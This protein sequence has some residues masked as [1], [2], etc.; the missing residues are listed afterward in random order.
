L[1][2]SE[3]EKMHVHMNRTALENLSEL[4]VEVDPNLPYI[5]IGG[6]DIKSWLMFQLEYVPSQFMRKLVSSSMG[7]KEWDWRQFPHLALVQR[8][9]QQTG[10]RLK[11]WLKL[12][13]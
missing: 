9:I 3:F 8:T 4:C 11:E 7:L 1:V 13:G 12:N 5:L 2:V 10:P 6:S